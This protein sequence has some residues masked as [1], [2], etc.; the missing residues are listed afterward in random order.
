MT[1]FYY[2]LFSSTRVSW[3]LNICYPFCVVGVMFVYKLLGVFV[4]RMSLTWTN[5][6]L[7]VGF[8]RET[9]QQVDV[10]PGCQRDWT[11]SQP[12]LYQTSYLKGSFIIN[13]SCIY[14]QPL[15]YGRSLTAPRLRSKCTGHAPFGVRQRSTNF[16]CTCDVKV[17]ASVSDDLTSCTFQSRRRVPR[18]VEV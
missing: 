5:C 16:E 9:W 7:F 4:R 1:C 6:I 11:V 13:I 14:S 8:V 18:R 3:Y 2:T 12:S 17:P 10:V 15:R